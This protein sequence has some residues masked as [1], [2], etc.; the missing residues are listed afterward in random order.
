MLFGCANTATQCCPSRTETRPETL[1][2]CVNLAAGTS[3]PLP[4]V[5]P[6]IQDVCSAGRE[7][8]ERPSF[9]RNNS[10]S[11]FFETAANGKERVKSDFFPLFLP[12][13]ST[14]IVRAPAVGCRYF[15]VVTSGTRC[16]VSLAGCCCC[17]WCPL[18]G[19]GCALA[20][21]RSERISDIFPASFHS[22]SCRLSASSSGCCRKYPP[23]SAPILHHP[24]GQVLMVFCL[25]KMIA[26]KP[27]T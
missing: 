8:K 2:A 18:H 27:I 26:E 7:D 4:G 6:S 5:F 25:C 13:R 12:L 19:R 22:P 24:L 16:V 20:N 3:A 14:S 23:V 9:R 10:H 21:I 1:G 17:R 11:T 15:D